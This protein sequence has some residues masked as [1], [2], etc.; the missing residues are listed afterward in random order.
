MPRLRGLLKK[1]PIKSAILDPAYF[2]FLSNQ[3]A[4]FQAGL[5]GSGRDTP[6]RFGGWSDVQENSLWPS[7]NYGGTNPVA[8]LVCNPQAIGVVAGLPLSLPNS[9]N[10]LNETI[11]QIS[12]PDIYV[13]NY[14]WVSLGKRALFLS[15][16]LMFGAA[17]GDA[18]AAA[19]LF[20]GAGPRS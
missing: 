5:D 16:D 4:F 17:G 12:G 18:S 19:L 9:S 2:S 8:G 10:V 20:N 14:N 3:P 15:Y 7:L 13:A 1:S 11:T 6:I